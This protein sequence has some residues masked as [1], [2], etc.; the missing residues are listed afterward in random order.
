MD[1]SAKR[2]LTGAALALSLCCGNAAAQ[3]YAPAPTL[4]EAHEYLA[5]TFGRYLVGYTLWYGPGTRDNTRGLTG[6]AGRDCYSELGTGRVNRAFAVDWS[7]VSGIEPSGAEA[8]YV[9]GQLLRTAQ[10]PDARRYANFHLHFPNPGVTKGVAH[11]L[12]V[13]RA[14]CQRRT[15]F[16]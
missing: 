1:N 16:D 2:I 12:E 3:I 6:Y 9:S 11:A 5:G 4:A 15:K 10:N 14:S 7:M 8:I 13:L